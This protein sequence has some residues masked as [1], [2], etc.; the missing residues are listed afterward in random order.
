MVRTG[1]HLRASGSANAPA[2]E[3]GFLPDSIH[4][5]HANR[6]DCGCEHRPPHWVCSICKIVLCEVCHRRG[7]GCGCT[8][9]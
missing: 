9:T 8:L 5:V 1:R 7:M 2:W 4:D 6:N 3:T